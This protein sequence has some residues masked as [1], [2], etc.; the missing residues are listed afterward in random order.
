QGRGDTS[1]LLDR[2]VT[3]EGVVTGNFARH[4][5]GWFVQDAGDG[6]PVTSDG[7]FVVSEL[8]PG[9]RAGDRVR[10]R[11]RVV[12]H[13]E[14][15]RGTLTTLQAGAIEVTGRGDVTPVVLTAPPP[16]W[17]RYEGMRVR[18]EAPLAIGGQ[19]QLSRRGVLHAS[20]GGRLATPTELAAPGPG[21]ARVEADNRRRRL[22]LDDARPSQNP[23]PAW[24][25]EGR[26][27]PP[28]AAAGRRQGQPDPRPG[29]VPGR[30][31]AAA[32]G[33]PGAGRGRDRRRA[34]GRAA[35]AADR[36]AADR[37]GATAGAADGARQAAPGRAQPAQ[38]VQ[39]RRP[40]RRVS[41][42][43][44]RAHPGPAA[45]PAG[46]A[47]GHPGRAGPAPGRADGARE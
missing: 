24:Y 21:T 6:D 2:T 36:A 29:L 8:D 15:G 27:P 44:R 23:V 30:P 4:L 35:A 26:R 9:L 34:L 46:A 13:G 3:V 47:G 40:R 32:A 37:A 5:G 20:F 12:E 22:L 33:Q 43:A 19:H 31:R 18:I 39:R 16:D 25:L 28:P 10:L 7:L 38:P 1:P 42:L 41:D 45:R 14:R 11:G 17:E